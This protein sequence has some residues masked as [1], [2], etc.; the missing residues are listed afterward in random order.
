[1]FLKRTEKMMCICSAHF[2]AL[3]PIIHHVLAHYNALIRTD[4]WQD[5]AM[6]RLLSNNA[7]RLF[8]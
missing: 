1:M 2:N 6:P 8:A 4:G 7:V 3:S 5:K